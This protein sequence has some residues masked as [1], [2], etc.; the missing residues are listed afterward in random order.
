LST[1][2]RVRALSA[3]RT[4]VTT[5]G[6]TAIGLGRLIARTE[7]G[8]RVR[9]AVGDC[10][11]E[12]ELSGSDGRMYR[13][14]EFRGREAVVLAWFPKAFTRGCAAECRSL[15]QYG[16]ELERFRVRCFGANVDRVG[17]NRRFA[18]S[19]GID[20]PI[21]SDPDKDA[22]RAYGVLGPSGFPSRWTFYIGLDGRILAVDTEVASASH[23]LDVAARLTELAVPLRG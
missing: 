18:A 3:L 14:S 21:L 1:P 2:R 8:E 11:P 22:A 9:L 17:T 15:Q 13:L 16:S 4:I 23:G 12:F 7:R 20:F 6:S 19:L 5:A 10:A